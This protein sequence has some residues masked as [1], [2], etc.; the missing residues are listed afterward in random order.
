MVIIIV[1]AIVE[2][3]G[4]VI[5]LIAGQY[6]VRIKFA[7]YNEVVIGGIVEIIYVVIRQDLVDIAAFVSTV[8]VGRGVRY[9]I[10]TRLAM[11]GIVVVVRFSSLVVSHI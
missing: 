4:C 3:V 2:D 1:V 7:T 10:V 9:V 5:V 11:V 8:V 6:L